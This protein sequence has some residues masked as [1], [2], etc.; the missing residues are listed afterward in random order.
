MKP[1][2][3]YLI[4]GIVIALIGILSIKRNSNKKKRC[5]ASAR[6]VIVEVETDSEESEENTK[7]K[8][9]YTPIFEFK[10]DDDVIRKSGGVYSHNKKK[11][12]V[13]DTEDVF[14]NP[15][16]P[17]EFFVKGK[18]SGNAFGI[19]LVLFGILV[20]AIAFTQL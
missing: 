11:Y 15:K 17:K 3:I 14:Y 20:I 5:S 7:K 6:A 16:K 18:D 19:A 9:T 4:V 8:Y 12:R 13:G 1:F 2:V 10:A